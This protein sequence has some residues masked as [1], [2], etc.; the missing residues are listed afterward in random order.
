[1]KNDLW[2]Q[3]VFPSVAAATML[4]IALG[5]I[6][7][8]GLFEL[9]NDETGTRP[10]AASVGVIGAVFSAA[11]VLIGMMVKYSIDDRNVQIATQVQKSNRV[12]TVIR[13]VALLSENNK[14]ATINQIEGVLLALVS[15]EELELATRLL[16]IYWPRWVSSHVAEAVFATS[17]DKGSEAAR[18]LAAVILWENAHLISQDGHSIWPLKSWNVDLGLNCRYSLVS[19]ACEW[20]ISQFE[21][22]RQQLPEAA[23][24]L[25][26]ALDDPEFSVSQTAAACLRPLIQALPIN[27]SVLD[28]FNIGKML[29]VNDINAKLPAHPDSSTTNWDAYGARIQAISTNSSSPLPPGELG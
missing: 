1:M 15:L 21:S 28:M 19:A 12:D 13:A 23:V 11:L 27:A 2:K 14:D 17:L 5:L 20:S 25:Y 4:G 6:W 7:W 24:V 3:W 22:G 18:D 29:Y 9:T 16:A 8:I 10:L 26:Q